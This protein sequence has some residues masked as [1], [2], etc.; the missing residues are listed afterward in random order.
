MI[1]DQINVDLTGGAGIAARRLHHALQQQGIDSRFWYLQSHSLKQ[2]DPSYHSLNAVRPGDSITKNFGIKLREWQQRLLHRVRR[3]YYLKG[4]RQRRDYFSSPEDHRRFA[5]QREHMQGNLLHL[6]WI[7]RQVDWP[8]LLNS[9]PE[10]LPVVW[11]FH[12]MNVLT[13]GCHHADDC[14]R[15]RTVCCECPILSRPGPTDLAHRNF[16]LKR[17]LLARLNL[18]VVLP[19]RWLENLARQSP[20]V[21]N[22]KSIQTIFNGLDISVF[23]PQVKALAR[24]AL[25][26]PTNSLLLA[27][28]ADSLKNR[29]KGI[30]EFMG[31]VERL[32][33]NIS[34]RLLL[35]GKD[36]P[37]VVSS[38]F[39]THHVGYVTDPS[40]QARIYSAAD[41][42]VMPSH[43]EN[44]PQTVIE[45][46]AC[47]TPVV[48]FDVGGIPEVVRPQE[49]GMLAKRFD[50]DELSA[51]ISWLADHPELRQRMGI[52]GRRLVEREFDHLRQTNRYLSLYERLIADIRPARRAA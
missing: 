22:A 5:Y 33:G 29:R 35:F 8:T 44:M 4:R 1:V 47:G 46:L 50:V 17:E 37:P 25:G 45:S 20:I 24:A 11:T 16:I 31:A 40:E 2:L 43:A 6:H 15:F 18:H 10:E 28:G 34:A 49:T 51:R 7:S 19:S 14:E 3:L 42:F 36:F 32:P 26:I 27:Y 30:V 23:R 41:L 13:G 38:R 21:A 52:A 48:A 9:I 12:D 39:P